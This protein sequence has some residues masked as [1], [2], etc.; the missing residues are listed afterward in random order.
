M[1]YLFSKNLSGNPEYIDRPVYHHGELLSYHEFRKRLK[2]NYPLLIW[3]LL[4]PWIM[5]SVSIIAFICT[6]NDFGSYV[7]IFPLAIFIAFWLQ[8]YTLHFHEAAHF[9]LHSNKKINDALALILFTPFVG[10][11]VGQYRI[12]H[13][14]HHRYL[15]TFQD[16]EISY[17]QHLSLLAIFEGITG[18]YLVKMLRKYKNNFSNIENRNKNNSGENNKFIIS[19]SIFMMCQ[20]MI[21]CCLYFYALENLIISWVLAIF[22]FAPLIARLRQTMEHRSFSADKNVD[23]ELVEHGQANRIF[24]KDFFSKYLGAAGFNSHLLHHLDPSI[25]YTRFDEMEEFLGNTDVKNYLNVHRIGY[26]QCIQ[27]LV[28][29]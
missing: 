7:L 22:I 12:S 3:R 21:V 17:R 27:K 24:G 14:R 15:G 19:L 26:Y 10:M 6:D 20:M 1:R 29:V 13:W 5:I 18:I 4:F 23:Y 25:S 9:N 2:I 28:Q 16:T 8:A 11:F